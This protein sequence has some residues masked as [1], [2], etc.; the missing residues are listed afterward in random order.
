M[1]FVNWFLGKRRRCSRAKA[2]GQFSSY[3]PS[4][5]TLEDRQCLSVAAPTGLHLTALSPTQ[6]QL[7]WTD[8]AGESGF[9]IEEWNG[10]QAVQI[11]KV[12]QHVTTFTATG[13]TPNQVQWFAVQAF[14]STTSAQGAW[15]SITT[16]A[17][18]ITAPTNLKFSNITT[19]QATLTWNAATGQTGYE[20]FQWN[21]SSSVQVGSVGATV[22]A[23]KVTNL[24]PGTANYFYVQ[25]SNATNFASSGWATVTTISPLLTAPGNLQATPIDAATIGLSWTNSVN[26]TGYN[27]YGWNGVSSSSPVVIATLAANTTGFQ[28]T[29][30]SPGQTYWFYV[31]AFTATTTANTAWVSR[32]HRSPR[33]RSRRRRKS[34][35]RSQAPASSRCRG[36]SP[37][38][39][40]V[41]TSSSGAASLGSWPAPSPRERTKRRLAAWRR[42]KLSG[43]WSSRSP[44]TTPR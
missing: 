25:S 41:T 5:E 1:S 12:G 42:I 43:S 37:P 30:L 20:I 44:P 23:F 9:H 13:L 18:A 4:A 19:N 33:R 38:A 11:G 15:A 35:R 3:V 39:R 34:R 28:A 24:T 14:D 17:D 21:G 6:V 8:V 7:T 16:P 36:S 22:T 29:G 31:Q 27:V 2:D 10:T 40:P 32:D 26:A